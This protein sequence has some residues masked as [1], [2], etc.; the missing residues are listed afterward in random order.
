MMITERHPP[1]NG[2]PPILMRALVL[3]LDGVGVGNAP[4]RR[5]TTIAG[6]HPRAYL[7]HR[8]TLE[9]PNLFSLPAE[10]FPATGMKQPGRVHAMDGCGPLPP[11]RSND[12]PL[13]NCRGRRDGTFC[14]MRMFPTPLVKAIEIEAGVEFIGNCAGA[15][16]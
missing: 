11:E 13:G 10:F 14:Q 8:Q 7:L 6:R 1:L 9:L 4:M 2:M 12:G 3:I 16:P 15:A 5:L